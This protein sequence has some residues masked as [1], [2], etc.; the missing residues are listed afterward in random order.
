MYPIISI[1]RNN[2]VIE[3]I[4]NAS[5]LYGGK[6]PDSWLEINYGSSN[7]D[8][9]AKIGK[10]MVV[11][12]DQVKNTT[13]LAGE[14]LQISLCMGMSVYNKTSYNQTIKPSIQIN[15]ADPSGISTIVPPA[16][17][18]L[19]STSGPNGTIL[20]SSNSTVGPPGPPGPQGPPGPPGPQGPPGSQGLQ[21]LQGPPPSDSKISDLIDKRIGDLSTEKLFCLALQKILNLSK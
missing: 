15:F 9:M 8:T 5:A 10:K 16:N 12:E 7:F 17:V 2:T 6:Y 4:Y 19:G 11:Y 3:E 1:I 21:G 14:K 20:G 18:Q 13:I